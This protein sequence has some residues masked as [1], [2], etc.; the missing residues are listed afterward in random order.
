MEPM[1]TQVYLS[2]STKNGSVGPLF[3]ND[4]G[5]LDMLRVVNQQSAA[6]AATEILSLVAL[7]G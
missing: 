2:T 4:L 3:P 7:S 6:F 5:A 1:S